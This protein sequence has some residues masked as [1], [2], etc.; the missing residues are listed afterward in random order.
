MYTQIMVTNLPDS[1]TNLEKNIYLQKLHP[2]QPYFLE[3]PLNM[4]GL[5]AFWLLQCYFPLTP[6]FYFPIFNLTLLFPL[7]LITLLSNNCAILDPNIVTGIDLCKNQD[8]TA[9]FSSRISAQSFSSYY[10]TV[11]ITQ[12]LHNNIKITDLC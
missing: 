7:H 3:T 5:L 12:K 10:I 4:T 9:T 2:L 1:G 8:I 11:W 6:L